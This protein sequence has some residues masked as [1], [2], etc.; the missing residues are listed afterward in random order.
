MAAGDRAA[1]LG[2]MAAEL[3]HLFFWYCGDLWG[4]ETYIQHL[5]ASYA[6]FVQA[7]AA[8]FATLTTRGRFHMACAQARMGC[9]RWLSPEYRRRLIADAEEMLTT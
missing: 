8:A 5:Y 9:N 1:D 4:G 7:D 2:Q 3:K 6:R